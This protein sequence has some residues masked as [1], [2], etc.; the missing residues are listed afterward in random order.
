M[1]YSRA[2]AEIAG[3]QNRRR[4]TN[5][6]RRPPEIAGATTPAINAVNSITF[7]LKVGT[8]D[9]T[10]GQSGL[11]YLPQMREGMH[12]L[13]FR[14]L[15]VW[16]N[17]QALGSLYPPAD[18]AHTEE[19]RQDLLLSFRT[20]TTMVN[21][22]RQ[23]G[24]GASQHPKTRL[25][26]SNLNNG[27]PRILRALATLLVRNNEIIAVTTLNN[28]GPD[29]Q[30]VAIDT[31][32]GATGGYGDPKWQGESGGGDDDDD[33]GNDGGDSD[34]ENH[35]ED[36]GARTGPSPRLSYFAVANPRR[37]TADSTVEI[38]TVQGS[39]EGPTD[40]L[41]AYLWKNRP[42]LPAGTKPQAN[43]KGGRYFHPNSE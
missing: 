25:P 43:K 42:S 34:G 20:L 4:A 13:T 41:M 36:G 1:A 2:T 11:I 33:D 5:Q 15:I 30:L 17:T 21:T 23:A 29:V 19:V 6:P 37:C 18:I 38:I 32:T 22:L 8:V 3:P 28:S 26:P 12:L 35:R 27:S 40:N 24:F 7:P 10:T 39:M 14:V 9:G 16:L 31:N